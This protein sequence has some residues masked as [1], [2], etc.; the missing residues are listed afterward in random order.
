MKRYST[1]PST[2]GGF[3]PKSNKKIKVA[4]NITLIKVFK[5]NPCALRFYAVKKWKNDI[6]GYTHD[7]TM[8]LNENKYFVQNLKIKCIGERR[9]PHNDEPLQSK[10]YNWR[11]CICVLEE[12]E[13]DDA[14][15]VAEEWGK[16]ITKLFQDKIGPN[17]RFPE[18]FEFGGVENKGSDEIHSVSR[19]LTCKSVVDVCKALFAD[20]IEDGSFF[21]DDELIFELFAGVN[22]VRALFD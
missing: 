10:G 7:L 13:L 6:A 4:T 9:N 19:F 22:N 1:A 17:F 20:K 8:A 2:K 3:S 11:M 5:M 14:D 12:D 21:H 15:D 16:K 18:V